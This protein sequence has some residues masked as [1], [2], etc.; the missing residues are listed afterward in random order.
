MLIPIFFSFA[1]AQ[2]TSPCSTAE[3]RPQDPMNTYNPSNFGKNY[4]LFVCV[5]DKTKR[6]EIDLRNLHVTDSKMTRAKKLSP[7]VI[8]DYKDSSVS[9][10]SFKQ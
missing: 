10:A 1:N 8:Y 9:R 6:L 7:D 4:L 2:I 5:R 3:N